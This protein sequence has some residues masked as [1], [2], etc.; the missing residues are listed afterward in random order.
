MSLEQCESFDGMSNARC[1]YHKG[2]SGDHYHSLE[3]ESYRIRWKIASDDRDQLRSAVQMLAA[4]NAR[5]CDRLIA[6]E[7]VVEAARKAAKS[8]EL[9]NSIHA[10][11]LQRLVEAYDA[12]KPS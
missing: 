6:A 4:D 9:R 5:L 12:G 11:T 1:C 3:D 8:V 10:P 2:H 7:K